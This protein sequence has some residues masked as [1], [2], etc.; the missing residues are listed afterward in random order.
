MRYLARLFSYRF[1]FAGVLLSYACPIVSNHTGFQTASVPLP[2]QSGW[3]EVANSK[4]ENVCP[5]STPAY[6][7]QHFCKNVIGAWSG[8]IVDTK[9]N[10]LIIWGGGH[11]DYYGNEL[12]AFDL[13]TLK[14]VRL[15]D[16]G[17][18]ASGVGCPESLADGTPNARHTYGGLAFISH[19]GRMFVFGGALA[20]R[21]G[22]TSQGTWTLDLDSLRWSRMDPVRGGHPSGG[23]SGS[24]A[25]YDPEAKRVF[26]NTRDSLWSYDYETNTYTLLNRAADLTLHTNAVIDTRR[27]LFLT[28][29][30][31]LIRSIGIG[32]GTK[33]AVH[34]LST[35]GCSELANSAS[36]GLAY[37]PDLERVVG[38]PNFGGTVYLFDPAT[39][40][41]SSRTFPG[42]PQD[43][44]HDG[45]PPNTNGTFGRFQYFSGPGVFALV[46]D[47]NINVH[48]LRLADLK[49]ADPGTERQPTPK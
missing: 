49:H 7:F 8:G 25:A 13:G 2:S 19:A 29:G 16:P 48:L 35:S 44:A 27:R 5:R 24:V 41:C 17:P 34:I 28:F 3:F 38:W 9:H 42:A 40:S 37:D 31:G 43:S 21:D 20:N 15:N 11:N 6:E 30:D 36:P 47:W 23:L 10:R 4:L 45:P 12:Y 46:N 32:P 39:N 18:L 33:Y 22:C 1:A 14:L 26:L